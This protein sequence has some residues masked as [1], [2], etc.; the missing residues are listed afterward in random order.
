[1][2][3]F[4]YLGPLK[5]HEYSISGFGS[6]FLSQSKEWPMSKA[7]ASKIYWPLGFC[8]VLLTDFFL[9]LTTSFSFYSYDHYSMSWAVFVSSLIPL[10]KLHTKS[11][12]V[13]TSCTTWSHTLPLH[14]RCV[15][16]DVITFLYC[17]ITRRASRRHTLKQTNTSHTSHEKGVY[18]SVRQRFSS[19]TQLVMTQ[20]RPSSIWS[21]LKRL[22]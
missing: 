13:F 5:G 8:L 9:L 18:R 7:K 3:L 20:R 22:L 10:H 6:K 2:Y 12:S 15:C 19:M 14:V 1:M 11:K 16:Q 17:K 4:T 21:T